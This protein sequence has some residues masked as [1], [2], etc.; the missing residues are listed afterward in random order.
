MYLAVAYFS[1]HS[2]EQDPL[3]VLSYFINQWRYN[4]QVIGREMAITLNQNNETGKIEFHIKVALPAQNSLM[5]EF[6]SDEVNQALTHLKQANMAFLGVELIGR[7]F[8]GE[9][10]SE[11][12]RSQF[13]ILYTTHLDT[14]SPVYNGE[15][16]RPIPLYQ[17]TNKQQ[18]LSS[19]I[20]RWQE[21]WQAC[22]QL[23]MHGDVLE[24]EALTQIAE[25]NSP[26]AK[27]GRSLCQE[28]EALT[29]VPT[30]YYLYRLGDDKLAELQRA[31]PSCGDPSWKIENAPLH[32]IFHFKCDKCR[33][34]SN[35]S[36][37][38]Q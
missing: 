4:G 6:N 30:Y 33:L 14:C 10:T 29:S 21:N 18:D 11:D 32:N 26:L 37:E 16:F 8:N 12:S 23:Q 38:I 34:I 35:L 15:D 3:A 20:L 5:T 22:D 31:C 19:R 13:Q 7:D 27:I 24:T 25:Y 9:I 28:I 2:S 17:L 1:Y 36:W